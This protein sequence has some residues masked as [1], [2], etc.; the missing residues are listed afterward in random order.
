MTKIE[1]AEHLDF[2]DA[3]LRTLGRSQHPIGAIAEYHRISGEQGRDH[4]A[5]LRA[6]LCPHVEDTEEH[7]YV[8]RCPKCEALRLPHYDFVCDCD[9]PLALEPDSNESLGLTDQRGAL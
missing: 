4:V 1:I 9:E 6:A 7:G 5:K 8:E 2:L 3:R